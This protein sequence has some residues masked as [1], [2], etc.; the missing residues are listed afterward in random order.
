[1]ILGNEF[2]IRAFVDADFVGDVISRRSCTGF[3]VLLNMAPIY[4]LSK[5]Q[6]CIET[7]S[8][9]N[10]FCAMKQYCE[11]LKGL[12]YKL[13]MIWIPVD[14]PCFIYGDNQSILW[15]TTMPESKLKK[16]SSSVAYHYVRE[17]VS[18]DEWRT[19]YIKTQENPSDILTKNFPVGV[20][21]CRKTRMILYDIY[22]GTNY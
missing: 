13:R 21:Q 5:K 8:F 11:Y 19:T 4:C 7:S 20:N 10:E 9:G 2:I 17:E 3:I 12:R 6:K 14:N 1:M 22:P 18:T 15:N 16:K